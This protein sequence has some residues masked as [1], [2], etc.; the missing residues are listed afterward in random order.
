MILFFNNFICIFKEEVENI[1]NIKKVTDNKVIKI[2]KIIKE[3]PQKPHFKIPLK[4][5]CICELCTCG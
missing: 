3:E 2:E 4:E 5:Q 1:T